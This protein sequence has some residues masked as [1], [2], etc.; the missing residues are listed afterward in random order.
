[1]FGNWAKAW[2]RTGCR[3][4]HVIHAYTIWLLAH[5]TFI[6]PCYSAGSVVEVSSWKPGI[7]TDFFPPLELPGHLWLTHV[8]WAEPFLRNG[9][10]TSSKYISLILWKPSVH[11]RVYKSRLLVPILSHVKSLLWR[12][13]TNRPH[14]L[15]STS[16]PIWHLLIILSLEAIDM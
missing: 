9:G 10:S 6:S 16:F 15:S 12:H 4:K 11:Y 7:L 14:L 8:N 1:M 3:N 13:L 5:V 2:R